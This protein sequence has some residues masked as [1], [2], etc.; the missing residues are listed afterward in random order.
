MLFGATAFAQ[1]PPPPEAAVPPA[2]A[3]LRMAFLDLQRIAAESTEGKPRAEGAG[4]DAEEV[5]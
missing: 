2:Q 1:A 3:P 4:A 5:R